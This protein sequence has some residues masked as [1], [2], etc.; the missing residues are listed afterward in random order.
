M[1]IALF[2]PKR[3]SLRSL[4]AYLA[5]SLRNALGGPALASFTLRNIDLTVCVDARSLFARQLAKYR[6]Y[7]HV[8]SNWL[9]RSF[10]AQSG[11][12]Y[13]D[14]G[15][16]FG[17]YTMLL[18]RCAGPTGRVVAIEPEP[19]N[20]ALLHQNL[21]SNACHNVAVLPKGVGAAAGNATLSLIDPGNPGAHSLRQG[22]AA[23]ASVSIAIERLDDLLR[24][25]PGPIALLK[26]DIEGFEA[27]AMLGAPETLQRT[28]LLLMEFSP[29]FVRACGRTPQQLAA[30]LGDAGFVPHLLHAAHLEPTTWQALLEK[31]ARLGAEHFWQTDLL[32]KRC[33]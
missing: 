19:G 24:P 14:V 25:Y 16:N 23:Y 21:A 33:A 27:D 32:L 18:S 22:E 6:A 12:L 9:L 10:C 4:A 20:L 17:W 28:E 3:R 5:L 1:P 31:D 2:A 13:V 29:R 26:M 15:A 7:E 30:L 11:G 8:N